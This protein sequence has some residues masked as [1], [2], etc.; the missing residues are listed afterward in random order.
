MAK[1]TKSGNKSTL[2]F[3]IIGIVL[4]VTVNY[5][6]SFVMATQYP[7]VAV[8]SNSMVPFFYRGDILVIKGASQDELKTGDVI[9]FSV[10]GRPV[11]IVHRIIA[12][13]PD[14]TYQTKGDANSDQHPWEKSIEFTQIKG[15]EIL[16]LPF[17]GWVKIGMT[18][19]LGQNILVLII[20]IIAVTF[21][22]LATNKNEKW[23]LKR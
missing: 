23:F 20:L 12:K 8:E 6:M 3:I 21:I 9:V 16:I 11:P 17:L 2:F 13:N 14:N 4:A 5:G 15:R 19:I 7:I 18:E 1:K 22:Y 10:P